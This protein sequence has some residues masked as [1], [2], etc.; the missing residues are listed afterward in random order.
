MPSA[1]D[2]PLAI[3]SLLIAASSSAK[4]HWPDHDRSARLRRIHVFAAEMANY[5]A[6]S[7]DDFR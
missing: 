4:P 2:R 3:R 6:L 5:Q 1:P 7:A